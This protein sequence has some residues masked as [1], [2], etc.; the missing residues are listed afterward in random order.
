MEIKSSSGITSLGRWLAA[1]QQTKDTVTIV[2]MN[3]LLLFGLMFGVAIPGLILYF[4]RWRLVREKGSRKGAATI[5]ALSCLHELLCAILF[6]SSSNQSELGDTSLIGCGYVLGML[7]SAA[8]FLVAT[9][10]TEEAVAA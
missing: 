4:L 5:W 10:N 7:I 8:G 3:I 6:L 2:L 1:I 9:T